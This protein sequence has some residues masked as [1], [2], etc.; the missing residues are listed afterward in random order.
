MD[1]VQNVEILVLKCISSFQC[2]LEITSSKSK[3][4]V[5]EPMQILSNSTH[6]ILYAYLMFTAEAV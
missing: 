1:Y 5:Q 6:S 2:V 4:Y 3:Q